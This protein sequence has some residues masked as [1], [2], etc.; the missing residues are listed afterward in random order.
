MHSIAWW[1]TVLVMIVATITDLW[2]RR[3]PN[4]LVVPFLVI[5]VAVGGYLGGWMGLGR[6]VFGALLGALALGVFYWVGGMGMGDVKLFASIGAW[7]GPSQLVF[8]FVFMGL[9]GG[10]MAFAWAICG[11]YVGD[12][13]TSTAELIFG[14]RTRGFRPPAGLNL[15][16]PKTRKMPYAP[17]IAL[18]TILSFFALA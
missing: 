14:V 4:W 8:A 9:A 1:P 12:W 16:N 5:G 15:A 3:I 10:L 6:S 18:G 7:I 2:S 17:A 11:G 13:G